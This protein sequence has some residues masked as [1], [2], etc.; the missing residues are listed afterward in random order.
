M[1]LIVEIG[2][3]LPDA[4]SYLSLE[5]VM[6]RLPNSFIKEWNELDPDERVDQLVAA[7]QFID[8]AFNWIGK[9]KTLEQ[10]MNWPRTEVYFQGHS[11]PGDSIPNVIKRAVGMALVLVKK[12]GIDVFISTGEAMI[13]KEKFAVMETEY[14]EPGLH[15]E[16]KSMYE[17][18]NKVLL[19]FYAAPSRGGVVSSDVLRV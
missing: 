8:T 4:N 1:E 3:G 17:D 2:N 10:G 11:V 19:G 9:R 16:Y 6:K 15:A 12:L 5:D 14:F 18:I 13:K 7:S